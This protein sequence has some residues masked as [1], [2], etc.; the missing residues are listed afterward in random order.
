MEKIM[1]QNSPQNHMPEHI[2]CQ[3]C[4]KQYS[5]SLMSESQAWQCASDVYMIKGQDYILSHYGSS[6]DTERHILIETHTL[7]HGLICDECI[8]K[9]LAEG[10]AKLDKNFNY[11]DNYTPKA[12]ENMPEYIECATCHTHYHQVFAST[13]AYDCAADVNAK[14]EEIYGYYGSCYDTQHYLIE[15]PGVLKVGVV[16]DNCLREAIENQVIVK[17]E[18]F[19]YWEEYQAQFPVL[20]DD[21]EE[22]K[23]F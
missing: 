14:G 17:D 15:K 16:C 6:H 12:E 18:A 9:A 20:P 1:N 19:S 8:D 13:Q 4:H 22:I 11:F 10:Q 3:S 5:Q 21:L 7:E 2:T 23:E